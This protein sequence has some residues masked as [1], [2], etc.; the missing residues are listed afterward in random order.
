MSPLL[1]QLSYTATDGVCTKWCVLRQEVCWR[2]CSQSS[3]RSKRSKERRETERCQPIKSGLSVSNERIAL[4]LI[5][6]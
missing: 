5:S 4:A 3:L 2:H 6:L 1:Y